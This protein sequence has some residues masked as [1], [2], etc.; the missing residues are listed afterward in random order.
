M[1]RP[2]PPPHT[3]TPRKEEEEAVDMGG[4]MLGCSGCLY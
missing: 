3:H 2:L 4:G 1:P